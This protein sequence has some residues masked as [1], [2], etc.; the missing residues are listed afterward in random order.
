M[1]P[2]IPIDIL[3]LDYA[4]AL[5]SVPHKRLLKQVQ[6]L[7]INGQALEWIHSFLTNRR[8]QVRANCELSEFKLV[9]SGVPQGSILGPVLFAIYVND[10]PSELD[11][12]IYSATTS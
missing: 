4:K 6:S 12:K 8:Q 3:F 9:L 2:D 5:D 7:G 1:M 10:I 11:T